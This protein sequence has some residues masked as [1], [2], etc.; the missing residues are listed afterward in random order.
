MFEIDDSDVRSAHGNREL[1]LA[2][3]DIV[4]LAPPRQTGRGRVSTK[5]LALEF[6]VPFSRNF[7]RRGLDTLKAFFVLL[8]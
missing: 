1:W 4:N 5:L 7:E 8:P 3:A 6:R 2:G